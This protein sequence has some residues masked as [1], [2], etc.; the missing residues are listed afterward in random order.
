[1][2][3]E[4]ERV[5]HGNK[6]IRQLLLKLPEFTFPK[7]LSYQGVHLNQSNEPRLLDGFIQ[8]LVERLRT[9]ARQ[10]AT[11]G[12]SRWVQKPSCERLLFKSLQSLGA[13][14]EDLNMLPMH[15]CIQMS[16]AIRNACGGKSW[17]TCS[18]SASVEFFGDGDGERI[19]TRDE[20]I[21]WLL[22]PPVSV[23]YIFYVSEYI[24]SSPNIK[25][26]PETM[27]TWLYLGVDALWGP[28]VVWYSKDGTNHLLHRKSVAFSDL[29]NLQFQ[30]GKPNHPTLPQMVGMN[31]LQM[32][33]L[34]LGL[35]H[36]FFIFAGTVLVVTKDCWC[37]HILNTPNFEFGVVSWNNLQALLSLGRRWW[38][39]VSLGFLLTLDFDLQMLEHPRI[40][41]MRWNLAKMQ[42]LEWQ[43]RKKPDLNH[44]GR[45]PH[46][47]TFF[48]SSEKFSQHWRETLQDSAPCVEG[49][50]LRK[51]GRF[52]QAKPVGAKSWRKK[53]VHRGL[54]MG[55]SLFGCH[56]SHKSVTWLMLLQLSNRKDDVFTKIVWR[57]FVTQLSFLLTITSCGFCLKIVQI[58][59]KTVSHRKIGI[60]WVKYHPFLDQPIPY[61]CIPHYISLYHYLSYSQNLG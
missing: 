53:S 55:S 41:R 23:V 31:H 15:L 16:Q 14:L 32:V 13:F 45:K 21:L 60:H 47:S 49:K 33:G 26:P 8:Q 24:P 35:S 34:W 37:C 28:F 25:H 12:F 7:G 20:Y 22:N 52:S 9:C 58:P 36:M 51:M 17:A 3:R 6:E 61:C 27:V 1:M 46:D 39:W 57:P 40:Q 56:K 43:V 10:H 5:Q 59:P 48:A 44:V 29:K 54:P 11:A 19:P 38:R 30:H 4:R 2:E 42:F 18:P 50:N